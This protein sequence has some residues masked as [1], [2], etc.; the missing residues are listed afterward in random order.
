MH[1]PYVAL[2]ME[3]GKELMRQKSVCLSLEALAKWWLCWIRVK[4]LEI[5][6][7]LVLLGHNFLQIPTLSNPG[8]Q[9]MFPYL[10]TMIT[11]SNH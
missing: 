10:F 8:F 2:D 3:K 11:Q 6:C 9:K 4:V 5:W 7:D 1:M